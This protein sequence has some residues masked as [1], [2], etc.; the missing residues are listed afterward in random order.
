MIETSTVHASATTNQ[1]GSLRVLEPLVFAGGLASI[2]IELSASRLIAPYFGNS[3]FIWANL[4]GLTLTY[5]AIGYWAGGRLADRYPDPRLLYTCTA[6]AAVSAGLIPIVARPIL[7]LSLDAFDRVAVGAFYGSLLGTVFL[8]AVPIT[9]L[10]FVTPFAIRL[11]MGSIQNAGATA[12][13]IYALS[14]VGSILGSFLPVLLLIP[15]FG[16]RITF[17][18]LSGG[19]LLL[20]LAGLLEAR[21]LR[22]SGVAVAFM[23]LLLVSPA[24]ATGAIKPPYRGELVYE[25]ESEYNYIQVLKDGDEFLLALNEGQAIHSIYNPDQLLTGGPWDYFMIAPLFNTASASL[26]PASA[27]MIGLAGG[28]AARQLLAAYPG[29]RV[30]GVEIDPVIA[31]LGRTYFGMTDPRINVIIADG[32]YALRISEQKYDIIGIDAYKQPYIPFQLTTREFFAEARDHLAPCGVVVVN[33]GR[34]ATDFRLVD[35]ISSTMRAV[36][37]SVYAIDVARFTNTMVVGTTCAASIDD[38]IVN[39]QKLGAGDV[40]RTVALDAVAAGNLREIPP[41]GRVFTDDLAPVELV[42]D[43]MIIDAAREETE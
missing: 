33:V 12:G 41:G 19:L 28:T 9:L 15:V 38:F 40:V 29:L 11:R 35:V 37:T 36:F 7:T 22:L 10:G 4:I 34:T 39:T 5:L 21:A 6:V 25:T 24:I 14:T 3:T 43:V 31:D 1:P 13:R 42:V 18:I 8:F 2:G 17:L 16:T 23:V 30:D 27:M 32:R 20:S 26:Q